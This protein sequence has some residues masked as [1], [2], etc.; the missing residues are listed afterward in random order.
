MATLRPCILILAAGLW[1][2]MPGISAAASSS[3]ADDALAILEKNC[4]ACHGSAQMSGLDLRERGTLLKG[5]SRGPAVAPGNAAESLLYQVAAHVGD[6]AMPPGSKEPLPAT[7]LETLSKWINQG[8]PWPGSAAEAKQG[9]EPEWWAFRKPL[10]PAV[11]EPA[12]HSN[13]VRNPIDAFILAKIE[14]KDLALA[15]TVSSGYLGSPRL[16][17]FNRPA[18]KS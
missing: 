13:L 6:L 12:K 10:P 8:A 14:E 9:A 5:G 7:D 16:F 11:P 4:L 2:G 17:R 18:S 1:L 3:L 15:P